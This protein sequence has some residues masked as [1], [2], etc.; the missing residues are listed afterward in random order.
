MKQIKHVIFDLN[1]LHQL[2]H[3]EEQENFPA[4]LNILSDR[5]Y[6]ITL[7]GENLQT[8]SLQLQFPQIHFIPH[9]SNQ[10]ETLLQEP[11]L[12]DPSCFWITDHPHLQKYLLEHNRFFAI[13]QQGE[14]SEGIM[15]QTLRELLYYLHPSEHTITMIGNQIIAMKNKVPDRPL[16]LGVGGPD[17]CGHSI[18]V[19][20]FVEYLEL[21]EQLVLGMDVT[22][23]QGTDFFLQS[24]QASYWNSPLTYQWLMDQVLRP[25]S[26]KERV[27]LEESPKDVPLTEETVSFPIFLTPEMIVV[28]WGV[29]P[30]IEDLNSLYDLRILLELTPK[31]A[32]ARLFGI[33][34]REDFDSSFIDT[35]LNKEGKMYQQ[36]LDTFAVLKQIDYR[37]DFD[38]FNAFSIKDEK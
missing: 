31:A 24:N 26:Q 38:N 16:I 14:F 37:I 20:L 25:F 35:Y 30:F 19:D 12:F 29:T 5:D 36:Y 9:A 3:K 22:E 4:I 23:I 28:I 10:W 2:D 27:W 18:F 17:E 7:I 33:D 15:Y 6:E 34:D 1:H 11:R 13:S 32:T 21:N 8:E